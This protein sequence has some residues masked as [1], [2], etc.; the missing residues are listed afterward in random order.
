MSDADRDVLQIKLSQHHSLDIVRL[1]KQRRFRVVFAER[2]GVQRRSSVEISFDQAFK[3]AK[4]LIVIDNN[5][6]MEGAGTDPDRP[7][8]LP[9]SEMVDMLKEYLD[10]RRAPTVSDDYDD[11]RTGATRVHMPKDPG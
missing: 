10:D 5:M 4:F 9:S 3:L 7:S 1:Q 6:E 2:F 8:L 11:P